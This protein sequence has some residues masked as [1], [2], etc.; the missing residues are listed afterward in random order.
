MEVTM[1]NLKCML[2]GHKKYN[3]HALKG[4]NIW[5]LYNALGEKLVSI[6]VCGRCGAV[7]SDL[8]R[9]YD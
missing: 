4:S 6:N 1:I 9:K 7:Y 8:G 3:P 5:V 2:Y